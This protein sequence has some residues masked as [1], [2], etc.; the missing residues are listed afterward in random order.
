MRSNVAS[1]SSVAKITPRS[2]PFASSS[3]IACLSAAEALGSAS[4]RLEDDL[5]IGL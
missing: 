4:G 3:A 2:W 5:D 1:T